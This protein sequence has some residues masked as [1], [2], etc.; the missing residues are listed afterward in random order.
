MTTDDPGHSIDPRSPADPLSLAEAVAAGEL[1]ESAAIGVLRSLHPTDPPRADAEV[2]ELR[3]LV[4][5]IR[6][7]RRHAEAF[8]E[9]TQP[10]HRAAPAG[11]STPLAPSPSATPG[12]RA[13][14]VRV[15]RVGGRVR[16]RPAAR[17][18]RWAPGLV[19]AA[20]VLVVAIVVGSNL[21]SGPVGTGPLQSGP[22][23]GA[24]TA[25]D[26]PTAT[27]SPSIAP[28]TPVV[29]PPSA[30]GVVGVPPIASQIL[31][32]APGIAYWTLSA[33][34][35]ITVAEWRPD[36]GRARIGFTVDTW[37][38]P[39]RADGRWVDRRVVAS[40]DGRHVAFVETASASQ[41]RI[42]VFG[43]NGTT[44]WTDP[45]PWSGVD[46][47]W[48]PDSSTLAIGHQPG[49]WR[50][51]TFGPSGAPTV[52]SFDLG[53]AYALLGFSRS[54]RTLY[55]YDTTG[56][57]EYWQR[58]IEFP[59]TGGVPTPVARFS[60]L[61]D[62]VA[63]SNGTTA[64]ST[65]DPVGRGRYSPGIDP[66]T[67]RVLDTGDLSGRLL[68]W[69]VRDGTTTTPLETGAARIPEVAWGPGGSIVVVDL[70]QASTPFRLREVDIHDPRT[71]IGPVFGIPAGT[72]WQSFDGV[73][74]STAL[75]GLGAERA[76]DVPYLGPDELVAIDLAT[77]TSAV[78]VSGSAGLTGLHVAG[79]VVAGQ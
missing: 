15:E 2:V 73:R 38:D 50:I 20:A 56:E 12:P 49:A 21:A 32:G 9:A 44:L 23:I 18:P 57:A 75:L 26:E 14:P 17:G 36:G 43:P 51:V 71:P 62:P 8:R 67:G 33:E 52:A 37:P 59:V 31:S 39:S 10:D 54:G 61:A 68:G 19:A 27:G 46:L 60:G 53:G 42:R 77:A 25:S 55:G 1:A 41:A 69:E 65:V 5:A 22:V 78:L 4:A 13:I 48:S 64:I 40:P 74:G 7:V 34:D 16:L 29:P 45:D 11:A 35:R 24:S 3:E 6:G 76:H 58:P 72:Y 28:A 79:W 63:T 30:T 66:Q 47:V 70:A